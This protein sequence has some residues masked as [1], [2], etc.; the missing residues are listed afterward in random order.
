MDDSKGGTATAL[1]I[2]LSAQFAQARSVVFQTHVGLDV[3]KE[4]LDQLMDKLNAVADRQ[5]A[6]YA[7]EGAQKQLEVETNA[8]Q[9]YARR[10]EEIEA[11]IQIKMTAEGKRNPK[12]TAQDEVQKKQA[13]DTLEEGKKRVAIAQ[14]FLDELKQKA[15]NRDGAN[16]GPSN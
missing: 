6:F 1:G 15:G 12:L 5:E 3:S 4:T 7:I 13:R 8:L 14:K 2:S 9:N 10:F 16:S 11:N